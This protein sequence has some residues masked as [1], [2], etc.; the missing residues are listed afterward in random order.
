MSSLS[1]VYCCFLCW[2]RFNM[3]ICHISTLADPKL[4]HPKDA[5]S[6]D[7]ASCLSG[8]FFTC[9]F[10]SVICILAQYFYIIFILTSRFH[11]FTLSINTNKVALPFTSLVTSYASLLFFN[12]LLPC[13]NNAY[14]TDHI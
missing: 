6:S 1:L 3:A 13:F 8:F 2:N 11:Q 4:S 12:S 7:L 5:T 10:S 14:P 9:I